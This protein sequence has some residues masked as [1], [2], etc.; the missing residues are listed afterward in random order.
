MIMRLSQQEQ[1]SGGNLFLYFVLAVAFRS[2]RVCFME[3]AQF[4]FLLHLQGQAGARSFGSSA[5]SGR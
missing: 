1:A 4:C 5:R 3:P 2:R